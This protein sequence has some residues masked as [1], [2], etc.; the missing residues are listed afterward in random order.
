M[1]IAFSLLQPHAGT[2]SN[3]TFSNAPESATGAV[4][5]SPAADSININESVTTTT[6]TFVTQHIGCFQR[7][8]EIVQPD[9]G[10]WYAVVV[11]DEI[12]LGLCD[13]ESTV[14]H[15]LVVKL[16]INDAGP[17][18]LEEDEPSYTEYRL[19]NGTL[20]TFGEK[21]FVNPS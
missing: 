2:S 11:Y 6:D 10:E 12:E 17:D 13:Q 16:D 7:T 4:V 3:N 8:D 20:L 19:L 14:Q 9:E 5:V 1:V 21:R 15:G 18:Y